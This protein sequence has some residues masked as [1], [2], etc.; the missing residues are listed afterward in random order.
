MALVCGNVR[1]LRQTLVMRPS[2]T[3]P[4][5]GS[6]LGRPSR[7]FV[8]HP[9]HHRFNMVR[10][11]MPTPDYREGNGDGNDAQRERGPMESV[12]N[13]PSAFPVADS[14]TMIEQLDEE[15]MSENPELRPLK[16]AV[17]RAHQRREEATGIREA[18]EA[19]AQEV[20][21]L[22]VNAESHLKDIQKLLEELQEELASRRE[23]CSTEACCGNCERAAQGG[24]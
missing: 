7:H 5:G 6:R 11:C 13:G 16:E 20:A 17:Q 19:E 24:Q 21:Q 23:E 14:I 8:F 10:Q 22:A 15:D 4:K 9:M 18:L 3:R 12:D 2:A 1:S